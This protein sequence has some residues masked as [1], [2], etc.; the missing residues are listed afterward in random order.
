MSHPKKVAPKV[1]IPMLMNGSVG[2]NFV[3][4]SARSGTSEKA[5]TA[6]TVDAAE[7]RM[8]EARAYRRLL[9]RRRKKVFQSR[10][11]GAEEALRAEEVEEE[12]E[13]F[14]VR[15]KDGV[16]KDNGVF[17]EEGFAANGVNLANSRR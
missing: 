15:H 12:V 14:L 2:T 13:A 17:V 10:T 6:P 4:V 16:K 9:V 11:S 5:T 3:M 7:V 8:E 1:A